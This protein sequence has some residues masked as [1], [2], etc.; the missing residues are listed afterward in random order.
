M[1]VEESVELG[2]VHLS[3]GFIVSER[4]GVAGVWGS[5]HKLGKNARG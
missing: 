5:R 2:D 3:L 1:H 4:A